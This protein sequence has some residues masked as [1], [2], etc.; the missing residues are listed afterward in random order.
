MMQNMEQELA[1]SHALPNRA[2][3]CKDQ[4]KRLTPIG[5]TIQLNW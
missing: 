1:I 3:K 2:E 5:I 4:E